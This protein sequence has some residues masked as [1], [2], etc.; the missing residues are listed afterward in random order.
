MYIAGMIFYLTVETAFY[1]GYWQDYN[2]QGQSCKYTLEKIL[3]CYSHCFG[4]N[5]GNPKCWS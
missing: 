1:Y 2:V 4:D 3:S 5:S